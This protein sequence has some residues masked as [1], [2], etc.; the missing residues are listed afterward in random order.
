RAG[1]S[2]FEGNE[3]LAEAYDLIEPFEQNGAQRDAAQGQIVLLVGSELDAEETIQPV[4]QKGDGPAR[5]GAACD[6]L[7][8]QRLRQALLQRTSSG[9]IDAQPVSLQTVG[10]RIVAFEDLDGDAIRLQPCARHNPPVPAPTI[11][12]FTRWPTACMPTSCLPA[13]GEPF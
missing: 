11:S 7:L 1:G 3:L 13:G 9:L 8:E 5:I 6:Q 10:G 2:L 12:T 4:I